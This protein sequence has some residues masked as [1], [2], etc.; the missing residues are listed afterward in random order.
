MTF[1]KE[2]TVCGA[3][4]WSGRAFQRLGAVD[5]PK[6]GIWSWE[7]WRSRLSLDLRVVLW[8]ESSYFK[9]RKGIAMNEMGRQCRDA[10]VGEM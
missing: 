8:R 10:R 3:F 1:L 5:T 9:I 4:R 7:A 6:R 2:P